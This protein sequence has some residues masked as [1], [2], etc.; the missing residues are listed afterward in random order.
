MSSCRVA[1]SR[2]CWRFR[3]WE[4]GHIH[5]AMRSSVL[6]SHRHDDDEVGGQLASGD[7]EQ[8][9]FLLAPGTTPVACF[10]PPTVPQCCCATST[11]AASPLV[12]VTFDVQCVAHDNTHLVDV[13]MSLSLG[14]RRKGKPSPRSVVDQRGYHS[15]IRR[16]MARDDS[17]AQQAT[18][19][20]S[21][22]ARKFLLTCDHS[23]PRLI[24][25]NSGHPDLRPE[26]KTP[27]PCC[28]P[29]A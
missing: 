24:E 26:G 20:T 19:C 15:A 16:D 11:G 28:G 25:A 9:T 10:F 23:R 18:R 4:R 3:V 29:A 22:F 13:R 6:C 17:T 7:W 2:L 1:G 12:D 21:L 27:L 8:N 5:T 14:C